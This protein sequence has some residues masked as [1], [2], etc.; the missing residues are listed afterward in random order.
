MVLILDKLGAGAPE[1][2]AELD[3]VSP[4]ELVSTVAL[5]DVADDPGDDNEAV[6]DVE[7]DVV[8]TE[9]LIV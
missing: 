7:L 9:V 2:I 8:R 6:E 4:I 5:G 3:V 1:D